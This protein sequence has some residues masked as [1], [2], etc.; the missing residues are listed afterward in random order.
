M[1]AKLKTFLGEFEIYI[2]AVL[3]A[4]MTILLFV[5]VVSRYVFNNSITWTEE[6]CTIMFVWMV[7]LGCAGAITRRKH[8]RIDAFLVAM[9]FRVRKV[10]LIIDDII[11]GIFSVYILIPMMQITTNYLVRGA[12]SPILRLPKFISY[13]MMPVCFVLIV[14]RIVPNIIRL[15]HE[16][17][18]DL[19]NT[20]PTIDMEALEAEAAAIK[21][22]KEREAGQ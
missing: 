14:I 15:I 17:E 21:A 2:G 16:E 22:E 20:A 9:P 7:Y 6:L 13:G 11:F 4:A 5:Q 10:L 1:N 19:G 3:F 18:K 12:V 8:L